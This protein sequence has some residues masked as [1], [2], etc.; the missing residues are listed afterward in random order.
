[1]NIIIKLIIFVNIF[2]RQIQYII[3]DK[4]QMTT[5]YIANIISNFNFSK[6]H[7]PQ[8]LRKHYK[9]IYN[10][11]LNETE[12]LNKF[13]KTGIPEE[14]SL[15]ER[16]YCILNDLSDRP[17]CQYCKKEYVSRFSITLNSYRKWCGPS[18]QASDPE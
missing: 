6:Y 12:Y 3:K 18:C 4:K 2:I 9:R 1:M 10:R 5:K 11:I 14:I 16:L 7:L 13:S 15:F 17:L 8:Y